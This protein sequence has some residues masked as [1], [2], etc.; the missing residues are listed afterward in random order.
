MADPIFTGPIPEQ[1]ATEDQLFT[2]NVSGFFSDPD[3]DPLTYSASLPDGLTINDTT[4][5]ITGQPTNNAV[6]DN[7]TITV[8][9]SDGT[10]SV[11]GAFILNVANTN[12]DPT[13]VTAIGPQ[14]ATQGTDFTLDISGNFEDVDVGDTLEFTA[15][16]LPDGVIL[17]TNG[18]FSGAPTNDAALIGSY[19][20]TVTATDGSNKSVSNSFVITVA[21]INDPPTFTPSTTPTTTATEDNFFVYAVSGFFEDIDNDILTFT[22]ANLP[23]GLI[24]SSAGVISGTPT[25]DAVGVQTVTVTASDSRGGSIDGDVQITVTNT[26]DRPFVQTPIPDQPVSGTILEDASFT[27]DISSNFDDVDAT[28][29]LSFS[30]TGLPDGLTISPAGVITGSP[31]NDAALIGE[32]VVTVTA[33]DNSGSPNN[34]IS[35][36]F[37]MTVTNDND[38]PETNGTIG[39][40]TVTEDAFS[41]FSVNSFFRDIDGD[42]L[43]FTATG[44]PTGLTISP[45]G[46]ISGTAVNVPAPTSNVF[47][48][49]VTASDGQGGTDA[50]QQFQI[51]VNNTNDAPTA[52]AIPNQTATE[53][54][55]FSVDVSDF[56]ADED[57]GDS[58]TFSAV[59]LPDGL[60]ITTAGVIEG[61]PTNDAVGVSTATITA[62]DTSGETVEAT[63]QITVT[64]VNDPPELIAP[65]ISDR[66]AG[67]DTFFTMTVA[68]NFT[69]IDVGDT[70]SYFATGLPDGI[71]INNNTGVISG[72]ATNDAAVNSPHTVNIQVTDGNGGLASDDFT[73]TVTNTND[74]PQVALEIL[75][76][77][78]TEDQAFTL[79]IAPNFEDIDPADTLS[80]TATGLPDGL[81]I[82]TTGTISGTPTND[83]VGTSAV[84]VT[85]TDSA[86]ATVSDTFNITVANR[87]D[88]PT[89]D[90]EI[91]DQTATEDV[92][93]SLDI[94][95]NFSDIDQTDSLSFFASN[96]PDG[97]TIGATTGIISGTPTNDAAQGGTAGAYNVTVTATDGNGGIAGDT[98]TIT[99]Q[100]TN[101]APEVTTPISDRN[102]TEDASFALNVTNNFEDIDGDTL[103]YSVTGLPD[104]LTFTNGVFGG[105]PTNDAVGANTVTVTADDSN[106]GTVSDSFVITVQNTNDDPD[107]ATEIPDQNATEDQAFSLNISSNFKDIDGDTLT[108]FASGLPQGLSMDTN[109]GVI[110]GSPTNEAVGTST[111]TVTANDGNGGIIN[112]QFALT[113]ANANDAPVVDNVISDEI[114]AEDQT[115]TLDISNNFSD[116]DDGDTLT[117]SATGLPDGLTIS[118]AGEISG[119]PTNDAVGTNAVTVTA[120]DGNG[121]TVSDEFSLTVTNVND[122]PTVASPIPNVGATVGL[123]FS[124]NISGNFTDVDQGTT[125]TF[126]AEGLPDGF[127]F[128]GATGAITGT[129]TATGESTVKITADDQNGGSVVDEFLLTVSTNNPPGVVGAIPDRT[130]AANQ[131]FSFTVS[132]SVF[133]DTDPSD[134]LTF[135]ASQADGSPLPAW[136]AFDPASLTFSGTAPGEGMVSVRVTATDKA[137]NTAS[138]IFDLTINVAETPG[139]PTDPSNSGGS[140][141]SDGAN[142]DGNSGSDTPGSTPP[143][144]V[145]P[146]TNPIIAGTNGRDRLTG[147]AGDDQIEGQGGNDR[148]VGLDGSDTLIGGSGNDTIR[149]GNGDDV[150]YGGTGIDT[151]VGGNGA[152]IFVLET[153]AG[154]VKVNDFNDG[155]DRVGWGRG[156]RLGSLNVELVRGR[157]SLISAGNDPLMVLLNVQPNVLSRADLARV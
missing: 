91:D 74:A 18:V 26:N 102:A 145:V 114:I 104:G 121:G 142:G 106:G 61:N 60:T 27:L 111:V 23:D 136:L 77:S 115:F 35:D 117:F 88:P 92:A 43:T 46:V 108:F 76:R 124:L 58:L 41:T 71:T 64:N 140:G 68:G 48:V 137:S 31:T 24:I 65:G 86:N 123:D 99:V 70:L 4:G 17:G 15:T 50:S 25:N 72:F 152:D 132:E 84:T 69:D 97:L 141:N 49:T 105:S 53:D 3:S 147:T 40:R 127:S 122:D 36:T 56:F 126:L 79:N 133:N 29:T 47:D 62:E 144:P 22:S 146:P 95:G 5:V 155:E 148:L 20:V 21:D 54:T 129:P 156:I 118:G 157:H 80:F 125:F 2:I 30:A 63:V 59:D 107:V 55:V 78:A 113:V 13:L 57:Q 11:N 82:S 94:S 19:N 138:D 81:S 128:D 10:G 150:C 33:T 39:A 34:S 51:T 135:S 100:N 130:E 120:S 131:A 90:T 42:V 101:D 73:I 75:D 83:A 153:G 14:N 109:S 134:A 38:D 103:T 96:L 44:L 149:G 28:D 139:D 37:T 6:G 93:F 87:N 8:T 9:A 151:I 16:N 154:Y 1:N 32:H 112:D 110:S 66:T 45:T 52:S 116:P 119:T 89:L 67:E 7:Q 143:A 12:D 98:F 85:A